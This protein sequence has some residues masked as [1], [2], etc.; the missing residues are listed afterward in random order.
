[1]GKKSKR[2]AGGASVQ[3]TQAGV[4]MNNRAVCR[5]V[6][7]LWESKSS[8]HSFKKL[9]R[10][11]LSIHVCSGAYLLPVLIIGA[12]LI[13][14]GTLHFSN[15]AGTICTHSIL[16][17]GSSL[18]SGVVSCIFLYPL[19]MHIINAQIKGVSLFCSNY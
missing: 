8:F 18:I 19:S 2:Q 15:I 17:K 5:A 4:V 9:G 1:M 6:N 7:E 14:R 16:V 12:Y 13:F 11:V 10:N 3:R